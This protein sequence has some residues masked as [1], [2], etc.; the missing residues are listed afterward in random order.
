MYVAPLLAAPTGVSG[1]GPMI[2][3][4]GVVGR[5]VPVT[6][7]AEGLANGE[8]GAARPVAE[9][10]PARPV[11]EGSPAALVAGSAD[12]RPVTEDAAGVPVAEDGVARPAVGRNGGDGNGRGDDVFFDRGDD[13][14]DGRLPG[15]RRGVCGM[16]GLGI[17][18]QGERR[19]S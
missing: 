16:R 8:P 15:R 13:A 12:A 10:R 17:L 4:R 1:G 6:T 9:G 7:G 2:V 18:N 14:F 11:A 3:P 19:K 5:A